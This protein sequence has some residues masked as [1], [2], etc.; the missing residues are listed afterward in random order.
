MLKPRRFLLL[1]GLLLPLSASALEPVDLAIVAESPAGRFLLQEAGFDEDAVATL[2]RGTDG[3][4]PDRVRDIQR[5]IGKVRRDYLNDRPKDEALFEP[6]EEGELVLRA[7]QERALRDAIGENGAFSDVE[8][9]ARTYVA[10]RARFLRAAPAEPKIASMP[11][12]AEIHV[13]VNKDTAATLFSLARGDWESGFD[14]DELRAIA[15]AAQTRPLTAAERAR[16][17]TVRKHASIL[18]SAFQ[19][20]GDTHVAPKQLHEF[21]RDFGKLNDA[22][23]S[24]VDSAVAPAA[25]QFEATLDPDGLERAIKQFAP[26]SRASFDAHVKELFDE[27]ATLARKPTLPAEQFHELRKQMKEMLTVLQLLERSEPYEDTRLAYEYLFELNEEMG[28]LHDDV[29][30][31]AIRGE[32][33]Y[34]GS[35]I[36]VPPTIRAATQRFMARF[37]NVK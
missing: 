12:P 6:A 7:S 10:N 9:A 24:G 3:F 32:G 15:D 31:R 26:A 34:D 11:L 20:L 5:A 14:G 1:F 25:R 23:E 28:A 22:L 29:V 2:A 13:S 18:R 21:V 30:A 37:A 19:L 27:V 33:K 17:K 36:Q 16:L 4:D 8:S 35:T